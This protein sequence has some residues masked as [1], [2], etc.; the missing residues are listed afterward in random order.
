ME[1]RWR[2]L[3]A[4]CV[5]TAVSWIV[6]CGET[7]A[8]VGRV[9]AEPSEIRLLYPGF[10]GY[11]LE[12]SPEAPLDGVEGELR[13]SIHLVGDEGQVLRT[14]D[15][16][17]EREWSP[18]ATSVTEHMLYQSALA[19]P[20]GVGRYRLE[21]GLYDGAGNGWEVVSNEPTARVE[22][23]SQG[24]PAFYFS[25]EWQPIESGTDLQI[26]GRRWLRADGVLRLGELTA[27]GRLWLQ[28]AIPA[29]LAGEQLLELDPEAAEPEVVV[30]CSCGD[31]TEVRRGSG[32]HQVMLSIV[33][34]ADPEVPPECEISFDANYTLIG[35]EDRVRRTV[36]LE[37]LSWLSR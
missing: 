32:S 16:K 28:I 19:P 5:L 29:P 17:L 20:L 7:A 37:S 33:P 12:W 2:R 26:L 14:F 8:P 27:P 23:S 36:A 6:A 10:S 13:A 4:V 21:I 34:P 11:R 22:D 3:P 15:Q 35:V 18:G 24:F 9:T 1:K 30:H 25:P 31:V